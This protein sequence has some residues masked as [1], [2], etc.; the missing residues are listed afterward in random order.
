MFV[1]VVVGKCQNILHLCVYNCRWLC[2][3][4]VFSHFLYIFFYRFHM[5]TFIHMWSI[6]LRIS[7]I[8]FATQKSDSSVCYGSMVAVLLHQHSCTVCRMTQTFKWINFVNMWRATANEK[9]DKFYEMEICT[10]D[11]SLGKYFY[12]HTHTQTHRVLFGL[13]KC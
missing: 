13:Y 1:A 4:P 6:V 3:Y 8:I 12:A 10:P 2:F 9:S 5:P 7:L 11:K